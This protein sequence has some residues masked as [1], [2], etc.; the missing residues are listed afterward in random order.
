MT[1]NTIIETRALA[2]KVLAVAIINYEGA[3]YLL[4]DWSCYIDAVPGDSHDVEKFAVQLTGCKQSMEMASVLF[5]HL[6]IDKYR[7]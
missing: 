5:P 1:R 2:Q 7:S 6:P 3:D 4:F